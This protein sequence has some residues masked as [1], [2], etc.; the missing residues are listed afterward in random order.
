MVKCCLLSDKKK[1]LHPTAG[2]RLGSKDVM[3][4][5]KIENA[6]N[7]WHCPFKLKHFFLSF[8]ILFLKLFAWWKN[9]WISC[10]TCTLWMIILF[11]SI[12]IFPEVSRIR[13][14]IFFML[15]LKEMQQIISLLLLKEN[16]TSLR[17]LHKKFLV[18]K[19]VQQIYI[20]IEKR[21]TVGNYFWYSS[22]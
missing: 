7:L 20:R 4:E 22:G 15:N 19:H 3:L 5:A 21:S 18:R 14:L 6:T 11:W 2:N 8:Y 13:W 9:G 10:H 17:N 12:I 1:S 16:L